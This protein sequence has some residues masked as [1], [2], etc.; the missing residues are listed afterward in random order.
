[1]S[2]IQRAQ[3]TARM[4]KIVCHGSLVFLSGQTAHDSESANGEIAA[5]VQATLSRVDKLLTEAGS[6]LTRIL[7]ATIYLRNIS[8]FAVMNQVWE[9]W[10][11]RGA[12]PARTTVEARLASENLLFEITVT[13]A[14]KPGPAI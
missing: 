14:L 5:Q 6:D 10:L 1:M 8:D 12:A 2:N 3:T 13:A 9:S 11:P 4:S 7:S